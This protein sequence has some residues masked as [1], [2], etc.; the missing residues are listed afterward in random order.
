MNAE[1]LRELLRRQPFEPFELRLSDGDVHQIRHPENM[2]A[3]GSRGLVHYPDKDRV[4]IISLLHINAI[5]MINQV[6]N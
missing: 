5:E 3:G 2:W 6:D 1:A 4:V